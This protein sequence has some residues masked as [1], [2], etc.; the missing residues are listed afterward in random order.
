MKKVLVLFTLAVVFN[1]CA[2]KSV[3]EGE[4]DDII[5]AR[6]CSVED[7]NYLVMLEAVFQATSTEFCGNSEYRIIL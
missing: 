5:K 6:I 7:K 2:F 3:M 1:G 4:A